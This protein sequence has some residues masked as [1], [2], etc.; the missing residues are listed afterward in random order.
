[1]DKPV[2]P[3]ALKSAGADYQKR[4]K[5]LGLDPEGVLWAFDQQEH[6]FHLWLVW[7]GVDA[8]GPYQLTKLLFKAYR[9]SAL[10]QE[11]DPFTV[12]VLSP[13]ARMAHALRKLLA[14]ADEK[15]PQEMKVT[16]DP[17]GT[18]EVI[19][20]KS[21]WIY[22]FDKKDLSAPKVR[23]DWKRFQSNVSALAA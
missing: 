1:M 6:K 15:G 16:A 8:F 7:S 3:E 9:L 18:D 21:A 10:P 22:K 23:R 4:L 17:D 20:F 19:R 11:I 13:R 2:L 5:A 14:V 12:E